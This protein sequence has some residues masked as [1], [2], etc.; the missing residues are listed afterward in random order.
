[1]QACMK[2]SR[3]LWASPIL[4][5]ALALTACGGG[6]GSSP[7]GGGGLPAP[8]PTVAPGS[9]AITNSVARSDMQT[10]LTGV[11]V[12]TSFVSTTAGLG[13]SL[14]VARKIRALAQRHAL[15]T[16]TTT[17]CTN[18]QIETTVTSTSGASETITDDTYYDSACTALESQSITLATVTSVSPVIANATDQITTFSPT[19]SVT[20]FSTV[21][22]AI[23]DTTTQEVVTIQAN[24]SLSSGA[25]PFG[26]FG[27]TCTAALSNTTLLT[28][29][30]ASVD[31]VANV[32][33]GITISLNGSLAT[34]TA[35]SLA[36][37]L[38]ISSYTGSGLTIAPPLTGTTWAVSGGTLADTLTA[39]LNVS[40]SGPATSLTFTATDPASGATIALNEPTNT[41]TI[42]GTLTKGGKTVATLTI[43]T[44]G[45]GT[46]T[47]PDGTIGTITDFTIVS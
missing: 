10:A 20:G 24:E 41:T 26:T 21:T 38:T 2:T 34:T 33:T 22:L 28:C 12:G 39:S 47:Y 8:V 32:T 35:E 17:P 6:G 18:N 43:N 19:G 13:E 5:S 46:I 7:S 15:D 42:N 36:L 29:G 44:S 27:V 3:F 45:N 14:S 37:M 25:P 16:T 4:A 11:Q 9:V 1:M 23:N 31:T 40:L 30:A